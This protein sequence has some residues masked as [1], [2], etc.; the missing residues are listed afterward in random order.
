MW[1]YDTQETSGMVGRQHT[2]MVQ[3]PS[4]LYHSFGNVLTGCSCCSFGRR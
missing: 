1:W 2:L 4:V 3:A